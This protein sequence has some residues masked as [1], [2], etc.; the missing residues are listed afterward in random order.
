MTRRKRSQ[1]RGRE[2]REGK[3]VEEEKERGEKRERREQEGRTPRVECITK[4]NTAI[5]LYCLG[6]CLCVSLLSICRCPHKYLIRC[7]HLL[8][9]QDRKNLHTRFGRK[10]FQQLSRL[11]CRFLTTSSNINK[12]RI[13]NVE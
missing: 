4:L 5:P 8:V 11:A 10:Q 6:V 3:E 1:R 7:L 2:N 13:S 9:Q 12:N